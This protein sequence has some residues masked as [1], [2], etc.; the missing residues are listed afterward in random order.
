MCNSA[1]S[2]AADCPILK[3]LQNVSQRCESAEDYNVQTDHR[4]VAAVLKSNFM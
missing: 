2:L 1:L 3:L 4:L